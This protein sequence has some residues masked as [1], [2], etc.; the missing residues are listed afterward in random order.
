MHDGRVS[1]F[2]TGFDIGYQN[3]IRNGFILGKQKGLLSAEP[4]ACN[5]NVKFDVQNDLILQRPSRGQC[6]LCTDKALIDN[7]ISDIV[8]LQTK[9]IN[10]IQ[11]TLKTRY[12]QTEP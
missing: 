4:D 8:E 2:Q 5:S 11:T 12:E 1:Q 7:S 9:H 6:I 3:G 10:Q